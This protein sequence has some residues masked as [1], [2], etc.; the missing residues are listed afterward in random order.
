MSPLIR[1]TKLILVRG[2]SAGG[3]LLG[4]RCEGGGTG[5]KG[6]N[7]SELHDV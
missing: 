2:K 4:G 7:K 5:K 1:T 3:G 6:G